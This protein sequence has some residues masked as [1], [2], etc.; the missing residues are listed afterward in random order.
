[1]NDLPTPRCDATIQSMKLVAPLT[2]YLAL[3]ITLFAGQV[4]HAQPA[5]PPL[6]ELQQQAVKTVRDSKTDLDDGFYSLME[7]A[8]K[9]DYDLLPVAPKL[10]VTALTQS[11]GEYRGGLSTI[12]GTFVGLHERFQVS[13]RGPWTGKLEQWAIRDEESKQIVMVYL[14]APP[15]VPPEGTRVTTVGRFFRL[16][17]NSE[18]TIEQKSFL[19]FVGRTAKIH[20]DGALPPLTATQ[21]RQVELAEDFSTQ[22]DRPPFYALLRNASTWSETIKS[23]PPLITHTDPLIA[24]PSEYRGMSLRVEGILARRA[25]M[26]T[27]QAGPWGDSVEQWVIRITDLDDER[28][29]SVVVYLTNPPNELAVKDR[30]KL[31]GRFFKIW[32]DVR[33]KK[34]SGQVP[35]NIPVLVGHSAEPLTTIT[36]SN[37]ASNDSTTT[38]ATIRAGL[39]AF[40]IIGFGLFMVRRHMARLKAGGASDLVEYRRQ[41]RIEQRAA[42]DATPGK[43]DESQEE[44]EPAPLPEN[45]IDALHALENRD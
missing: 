12:D 24:A 13:R 23:Y 8:T 1:M 7:N 29:E 16:W 38:G 26:R 10:S 5:P 22:I 36:R 32:R 15:A 21:R 41:A 37:V 31:V 9:W 20:Y 42:R 11:P 4:S 6:T 34:G 25:K 18:E 2:N 28:D 19:V 43:S 35:F 17:P 39:A 45:P 27:S 33:A 14:V 44:S 30:V 3:A 40:A